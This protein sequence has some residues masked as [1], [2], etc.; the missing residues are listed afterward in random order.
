MHRRREPS[1]QAQ[2]LLCAALT[3]L[4]VLSLVSSASAQL[5]AEVVTAGFTAPVAIV[6]DPLA[7]DVFFVA[8]QNGIV[9]AVKNGEIQSAPFLDLRAEVTADGESGLLGL[10]FAP[11]AGS[12]RVFVAFVSSTGQTVVAR[13]LRSTADPLVVDVSTPRFDLR[14]PSGQRFIARTALNHNG[15]NLVFGPDGY[16]YIGLGDGGGPTADPFNS[17]QTP[18]TLLGK[19]LRIDVNVL[20]DDPTGYRVPPDNPFVAYPQSMVLHEIWAFGFRNPWRYSFDDVGPGATGALIVADVGQDTREEIN[21]EPAGR[22]GRNYGWRIRE[23]TVASPGMPPTAPAYLPLTDPIVDYG[24]DIGGSIIGGFVYR[25][26]QLPP[27]FQ[28]RYF[29]AD[30]I[31]NRIFSVGLA[32]DAAGG[33]HVVDALEHTSELGNLGKILTF[34][35][36]LAGELYVASINGTVYRIAAMALPPA[37]VSLS[38]VVNGST[39]ALTWEGGTGG[40]PVATYRLE[41]GSQP[42]ASDLLVVPIA[43]SSFVANAVPNGLYYV[44]AR[45]LNAAGSSNASNE[46]AITVGC[47]A[48]P[49]AP[50]VPSAVVSGQNVTLS[51][52][53]VAGA[54]I[55]HIEAGSLSGHADLAVIPTAGTGFA[56]PVPSG[57]YFVRVRALNACGTSAASSEVVVPVPIAAA[58]RHRR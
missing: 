25:G 14:W 39:V 42:G 46:V 19:M 15:G 40:G 38:N 7:P 41:V 37:P 44:R 50:T 55:Y 32:L 52:S 5:K 24:R 20:P 49:T 27:A 45:A 51:W 4:S 43:G 33:A 47:A 21:Y 56:G 29:V 35:R 23:G 8:Q 48:A 11:V 31:S 1:F 34:G 18:T 28:G 2:R 6:P 9:H 12:R 30:F 17:A 36:D 22:G 57:T 16:L 3:L 53:S 58:D 54:S 10:A 26:S 13:F